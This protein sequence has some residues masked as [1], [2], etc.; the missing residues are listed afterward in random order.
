MVF[1]FL[2]CKNP[3]KNSNSQENIPL[4]IPEKIALAHGYN[5][6]DAVSEIKFTFNVDRDS[7]HF[8]RTWIW[9]PKENSI[10]AISQNDTLIYNRNAMDSIAHKVNAGFINDRYWLL[11]PFNLIWDSGNYSFEHSV[12][13]KAPISDA[14]MQKLTI[15]YTNEGGYTPGDAYDFYF[16][17]DFLIRE[18]TFR[19]GNQEEPSLSTTWEKYGD[20]EGL[21]LPQDHRKIEADYSLNFTDLVI[22]ME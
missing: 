21:K 7:T 12:D 8:E 13:Q 9:K 1:L 5:Q 20:F 22:K 19:K 17:D 3:Q 4:S 10:T 18:W 2:S 16:S 11:A 15:V 14:K 6:W